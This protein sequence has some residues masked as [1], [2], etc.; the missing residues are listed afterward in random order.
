[1]S[2]WIKS[3]HRDYFINEMALYILFYNMFKKIYKYT[4]KKRILSNFESSTY[5]YQ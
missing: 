1:M 3:E 4:K 2:E 5:M